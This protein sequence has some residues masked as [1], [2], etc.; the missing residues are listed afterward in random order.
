MGENEEVIDQELLDA[1]AAEPHD[2]TDEQKTKI[3]EAEKVMSPEK[4]ELQRE[5]TRWG[6][7]V[8][9][10]EEK[11]E[12]VVGEFETFKTARPAKAPV[13][14]PEPVEGDDPFA[15]ERAEIEE[16]FVTSPTVATRR[17]LDLDRKIAAAEKTSYET[18]Y[19]K[20]LSSYGDIGGVLAKAREGQ[21]LSEEEKDV[22]EI[23]EE[24]FTNFNVKR[25]NNAAVDAEINWANAKA[26]VRE[27]MAAEGRKPTYKGPGDK[28]K[29]HAGMPPGSQS[30]E[31]P[32]QKASVK[33]DEKLMKYAKWK[34]EKTG[35]P[36]D[37]VAAELA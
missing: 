16:L 32:E 4:I 12:K 7:K 14:T 5:K 23:Y 22:K 31:A 3:A 37:E 29:S 6:R 25:G 34:A 24:M 2:L 17:T 30:S 18:G 11:L 35:R 20:Q 19:V 13:E 27:K 15:D 36:L 21:E 28:S 8:K 26:A 9:G 10:L 1:F 33:L